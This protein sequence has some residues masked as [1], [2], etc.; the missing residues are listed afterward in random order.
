M[1]RAVLEHGSLQQEDVAI[2]EL[3]ELQ[4]AIIKHRRYGTPETRQHIIEEVADV[5]IML[6]QLLLI[7]G[8]N[9]FDAITD[10][11]LQRL[12]TRLDDEEKE[13]NKNDE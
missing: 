1:C 8:C 12:A 4:H 11:K 13:R 7:H 10:A 6:Y 5:S 9:S 2:E 3:A